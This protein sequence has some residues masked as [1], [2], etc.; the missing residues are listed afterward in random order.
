MTIQPAS[1]LRLALAML[2]MTSLLMGIVPPEPRILRSTPCQKRRPASVTTKEGN[3]SSVMI[4]PW[5]RPMPAV[6]RRA[7]VI[8][9]H[10]GQP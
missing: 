7:A 8:A 2:L 6:A 9:D 10:H 5:T 4:S 3:P 1:G